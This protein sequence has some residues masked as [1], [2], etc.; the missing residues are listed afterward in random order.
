[1][2]LL[3]IIALVVLSTS[4]L[5]QNLTV[6]VSASTQ[7]P[8]VNETF[9][10][11]YKLV[12]DGSGSVQI[13]G[14]IGVKKPS[15]DNFK[16]VSEKAGRSGFNFG[17]FD[18]E[19]ALHQYAVVLQPN[20]EGKYIIEP[21][22]F[23]IGGTEYKSQSVTI[24]VGTA[25][26][27]QV[28]APVKNPNL[29]GKI[30][31]S[32]SSIFK[33]EHIIATAKIYSRYTRLSLTDSDFPMADGF[34]NEEIKTGK[35]GW[36]VKTENV[37]GVMYNVY[38]VKKDLL[39]PQKTGELKIPS[40]SATLVADRS[41]FNGGTE[42]KISSNSPKIKVK[43]IPNAPANFSGMVGTFSMDAEISKTE[44]SQDEGVDVRVKIKGKGNLQQLDD[45]SLEFPL[46]FD[47]YDPQREEK[48]VAS[49]SGLSGFKTFS[50]LG[51]PRTG[52]EF[53]IGP[54]Q[55]VYFNTKSK[56]FETLASDIWKINVNNSS[57][58]SAIE[59]NTIDQQ[60]VTVLSDGIRH[61][62]E[63]SVLISKD[64]L[65]FYSWYFW[66]MYLG[67]LLI[68]LISSSVN[69]YLK[70]RPNNEHLT[71]QK[72][73]AK[74]ALSVLK[75]A[76]TNLNNNQMSDFHESMLS[77]LFSYLKNKIHMEI[78]SLNKETIQTSLATKG[79]QDETIT[80]FISIIEKCEIS[81]YTPTTEM[82][83]EDLYNSGIEIIKKLED[84][85]VN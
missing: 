7:N 57:D 66:L 54:I 49:T 33:G 17:G 5:G 73:A 45:L 16:I 39:Y 60:N 78:I 63:S 30:Q 67:P 31:V 48:I 79:A 8:K 6:K 38:T 64:Q 75:E 50:F 46:D 47:T 51:I 76:K 4:L 19:M 2:K 20:K 27:R 11:V 1:M 69:K 28:S 32:K 71:R 26:K 25:S 3:H 41:F 74:I 24:H 62:R 18:M 23:Q 42:I 53:N 72:K 13:N 36:P 85:L 40:F 70:K 12:L 44:L 10:L 52:G 21:V 84:E 81:R 43:S 56:Q 82:G 34:W 68:V 65:I 37:G 61:I 77:G 15:F 59:P 14:R 35:E 55:L 22:S 29:F 9:K 83:S 58:G 80:N